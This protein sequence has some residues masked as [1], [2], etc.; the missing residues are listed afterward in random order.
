MNSGTA[1]NKSFNF[2]AYYLIIQ[3]YQRKDYRLNFKTYFKAGRTNLI[4]IHRRLYSGGEIERGVTGVDEYEQSHR[5]LWKSWWQPW[6]AEFLR[7]RV[8][9]YSR[10]ES[11][12]LIPSESHA[13]PWLSHASTTSTRRWAPLCNS[14]A[15]EWH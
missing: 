8:V 13:R 6:S 2:H 12:Q 11:W 3:P 4:Y 7:S 9:L 1:W 15:G 14:K 10:E 5:S